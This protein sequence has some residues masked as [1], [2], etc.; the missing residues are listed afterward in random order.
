MDPRFVS[1]RPDGELAGSI[2]TFRWDLGGIPVELTWLYAGSSVGASD[3]G[4][5]QVGADTE[6][7]LGG[8]PADG[9]DVFVRVWYR[10]DGRWSFIDTTY[11]AASS[12]GLPSFIQPTPGEAL[13]GTSQRFQWQ[14]GTPIVDAWWLY[15]GAEV[16]GSEFAALSFTPDPDQ[17]LIEATVGGLPTEATADEDAV[18]HARL[19]YLV[20]GAWYFSDSLFTP[21]SAPVRTRDELTRELQGLVGATADGVVGPLTRAALNRNWLG[22]SETFD[23]SFAARFTNDPDLVRWVQARMAEQGGPMIRVTGQF[24]AETEAAVVQYLGRRGVVA[25]ESFLA[26]VEP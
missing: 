11:Q 17:D 4:A 1:P 2:Q 15:L 14:P 16:G 6:S 19:Y 20:G 8:L 24:D 10:V 23:P 12:P 7:S 5:R 22:R 26:L 18:V 13:D 3:Y 25:A 21:A 9:S